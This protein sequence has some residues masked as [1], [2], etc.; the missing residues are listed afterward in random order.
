MGFSTRS[1]MKKKNMV[2]LKKKEVLQRESFK[3]SPAPIVVNS[4]K[5]EVDG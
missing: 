1:F 2:D 5:H 4:F 3:E